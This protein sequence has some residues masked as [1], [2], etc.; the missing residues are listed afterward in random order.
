MKE[1]VIEVILMEDL[2]QT[3]EII[4]EIVDIIQDQIRDQD[5]LNTQ[6]DRIAHINQD[7]VM[8]IIK[9][10]IEIT[11]KIIPP[12][13]RIEIIFLIII[14]SLHMELIP[15]KGLDQNFFKNGKEVT[16]D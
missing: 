15:D 14:L 13:L 3:S 9:I 4:Q 12:D 8:I 11:V 16:N 1:I 10:K 2:D 7:Q 5:I 6:I